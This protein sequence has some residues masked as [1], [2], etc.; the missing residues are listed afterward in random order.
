MKRILL[1]ALLPTLL[2]AYAVAQEVRVED[3]SVV[4]TT[5]EMERAN[6]AKRFK[7]M[8]A[9]E[10]DAIYLLNLA[11]TC[12]QKFAERYVKGYQRGGYMFAERKDSLYRELMHMTPLDPVLPHPGLYAHC[13]CLVEQSVKRG[14][15]S[16]SREGTTCEKR[17]S[18]ECVSNAGTN[19]ALVHICNLLVDAGEGNGALGHRRLML[20]KDFHYAAAAQENRFFVLQFWRDL[21][22][23]TNYTYTRGEEQDS[24]QGTEQEEEEEESNKGEDE[25]DDAPSIP[26]EEIDYDTYVKMQFDH[27]EDDPLFYSR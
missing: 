2:L 23:D 24:D 9:L 13:V 21:S 22:G 18:G 5:E 6:T 16:H 7:E 25:E 1:L 8:S 4:F 14:Y 19:D 15:I 26:P 12:P 17:F 10:K 11:R 20:S 3:K 27:P